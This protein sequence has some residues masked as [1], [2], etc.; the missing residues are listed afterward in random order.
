MPFSAEIV[1]DSINPS[2]QRVTTFLVTYPRFIHGEFMT[3]RVFSRNSASSRAIPVIK[4]INQVLGEPAMPVAWGKNTKGMQSHEYFDGEDRSK[5]EQ[6]WK[7]AAQ[8]AVES[9]RKLLDLGL[10][11][12]IANRV[13]E[14]FMWMTVLVTATDWSNFFSLRVHK[15]AQPEFQYLSHMILGRYLLS[16]PV[17]KNWGEWHIP[18]GDKMPEGLDEATRKKIATARAA[19][20]SYLTIDG[21]I[22]PQKDISLH[23]SLAS[24]GHWSPFEHTCQAFDGQVKGN[25][26]GWKQYRH[27]FLNENRACDLEQLWESTHESKEIFGC[28]RK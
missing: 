8:S 13:L 24:D 27:E 22:D 15:A 18:F 2:K 5:C 16:N 6:A 14:P 28:W 4:V 1:A 7:E 25:F 26:N 21:V 20:T 11:K 9:A 23:D 12:Q 3:H 19:R 17:L 10:H